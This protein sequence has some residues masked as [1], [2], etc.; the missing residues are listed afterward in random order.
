[1]KREIRVLG[2][3][4]SPFKKEKDEEV[5]V[6][7]TFF[8]GGDFVDGILSTKITRDGIDAT[9][10]IIAMVKRSKFHPQ[11]QAILLDGIAFGGFNVVDIE[12][13]AKHTKI[14]TITIIRKNPDL[15]KIKATLKKLGMEEKFKLMEIAGKPVKV[16]L[17][18]GHIWIQ[19]KGCSLQK[20]V[21]IVRL[22]ATHSYIPEPIR[23]AHLIGQG[24]VDGE[25][26][27]AA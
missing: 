27:G 10:K 1:M 7:A 13:I 17:K 23:V 6:V 25:S 24:I 12:E 3:D 4:D 18:R 26:R 22:T 9:E 19:Y 14:P 5:L 20:A 16:T 2:I 21:E 11:L 15:V 8:R